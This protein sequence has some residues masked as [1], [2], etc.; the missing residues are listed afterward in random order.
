[1]IINAAGPWA[2]QVGALG[3]LKVEVSPSAGAM[4]T[5]DRRLCNMVI[6]LMAPPG[7]GDI[8]VPQR[9]TCILG[10]TSW[11]VEDPDQ[12]PVA[13]EHIEIIY[14]VAETMIPTV[15]Q[16]H[17]RGVM[18][19]AR[20]LLVVDGAGGRAATRGFACF[21]HSAAGAPGFFSVVGGKTTTARLMAE[22][23]ADKVCA[24]LGIE[25]A[26]RTQDFP[27]ASYRA[28]AQP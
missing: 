10:T 28:W 14:K 26:C 7:D 16:A 8:I 24:F 5:L 11:D 19:A 1:M 17:V 21:D 22:K 13:A 9:Q 20:P 6:N 23:V 12:I 15:R 18:A 4:V 2:A 3:G 27:L 25:A